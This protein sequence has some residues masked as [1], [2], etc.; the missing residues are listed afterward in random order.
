[1]H[2]A[3]HRTAYDLS[4][5][6]NPAIFFGGAIYPPEDRYRIADAAGIADFYKKA[7]A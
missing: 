1:M 5:Q 3:V 2:A 4:C 7:N 6:G